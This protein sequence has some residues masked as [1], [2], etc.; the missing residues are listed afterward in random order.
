MNPQTA[1]CPNAECPARGQCGKG[2]IRIHSLKEHRFVCRECGKTFA[3]TRGT[4]F[5]R[6]RE[7]ADLVTV[8]ITLLAHGCP[9]QAIVA[10]FA[11]DERT[12]ASWQQLDASH[13]QSVHEQLVERPREL[14]HVQAD[15]IRVKHQGGIVWMAMA[16][17]VS[18][19]L[20]L[21]GAVSQNRDTSLIRRLIERVRRCASKAAILFCTDGLS[22]YVSVI[23]RV[24]RDPL[25]TSRRGRP[26]LQEWTGILIAQ[27]VKRYR[28]RRVVAVERRVKQGSAPQVAKMIR[29]S[30]GQGV[31]NTAFIERIIATFRERLAP[32]VRR[33]R[34]LARQTKTLEQGMYLVGTIYN[35]CTMHE[36]L[37]VM[38]GTDGGDRLRCTP[39]MTAGITDHC[40]SVRELLSYHVPLPR[41]SP[42]PRRG[43]MSEAMKLKMMEWCT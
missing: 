40:W 24:F 18:T 32:L 7:T 19:R 42:P 41:W 35:F 26:R 8:V 21:G 10:A 4:P 39:A 36:S 15:E 3:Q 2:N 29:R 33:G 23:R 16:V 30:Q 20:W 25:H 5:Y 13:C 9:T 1:F 22:T 17:M 12:V 43:R 38:L 37:T 28:Q 31:I 14:D 27:V 11:L 6:L 34:A